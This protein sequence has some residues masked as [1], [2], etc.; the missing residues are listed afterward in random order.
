MSSQS[1][2]PTNAPRPSP[3]APPGGTGS[4]A[5]R[6][7]GLLLFGLSLG[8]F[9]VMLDTT[10]VTVALPAIGDDLSGSLTG[11]Q[12]VS[13]GYTLTFAALLLSAGALSDRYGG[14]KVFLTGLWLFAL[15]SGVSAAVGSMGALIALRALLGVAG[16]LLLPTSLA[17]IAHAYT[18]PAARARAMG[19]WAAISGTALAA[20]P[21]VGGV[22][23]DTLGW[24]AIFLINVPVALVS[25]V[26]TMKH[27]PV[28]A[29]KPAKGVDLPGQVAAVL[30]LAGLT[31]ALIESEPEGWGSAQVLGGLAVFVVAGAAF[32]LAERRPETAGHAPM[33][34]LTMFRNRTLSAGLFAGLLV[35]FGLSGVLFVLSLFFQ[36]AHGY[37]AF[38]TGLVFLPLTLPTAFNPIFTG[39][40]VGRIGARKP[41]IAGFLMMGV[42][43]LIQSASTSDTVL[44]LVVMCAG[45]LVL[46]FG[47]SFAIPPLMTAIV[48]SVP[49]EQSGIASGALNSARQTGAVL[50]VAVLGAVI[51]SGASVGS[52]TRLALVVA[53]VV[54]LAGAGVVT[55]YIG[56]PAAQSA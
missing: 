35:N 46:G 47:V 51:G 14:R 31:Y 43:V 10:V 9:M 37:S 28:S 18:E 16:A 24:Q 22:F 33:L 13:N 40:L 55:A 49:K 19:A 41:A 30:A 12:W 11:L 17:I 15:F 3:Q 45:L 39:R 56:R 34:P 52:G 53:G 25:I 23:T 21:L 48:G 32:V 2:S 5:R 1:A 54:L 29:P 8:Y 38:T 7:N 50:G 27:A 20:G 4:V 42:G 26:I 36:E 6:P 44:G